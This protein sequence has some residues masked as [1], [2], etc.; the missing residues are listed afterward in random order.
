VRCFGN[1][2]AI[3]ESIPSQGLYIYIMMMIDSTLNI[4][5]ECNALSAPENHTVCC[6]FTEESRRTV[7]AL[8]NSCIEGQTS[9]TK[10]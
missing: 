5:T 4:S 7:N 2:K 8:E 6:R 10:F 1:V 3:N 9:E